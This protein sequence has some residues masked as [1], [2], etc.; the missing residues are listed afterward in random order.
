MVYCVSEDYSGTVDEPGAQF[1][2][3][4]LAATMM[5]LFYVTDAFR[6]CEALGSGK[7]A[8]LRAKVIAGTSLALWFTVIVLG[9]Y[10]QPLQD[11]IS[12]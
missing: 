12:R 5:G 7:D 10:I 8:P 2:A 4:V 6:E 9:R 3:I 1:I 11:S